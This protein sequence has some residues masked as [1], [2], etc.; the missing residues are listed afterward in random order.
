MPGNRAGRQ[1]RL[2]QVVEVSRRS[3]PNTQGRG[4]ENADTP[5]EV[6]IPGELCTVS[7]S[8]PESDSVAGRLGGQGLSRWESRLGGGGNY[9][10]QS[11]PKGNEMIHLLPW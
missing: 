2:R 9:V 10:N 4:A 3:N 6:D 11:G 8:V 1:G 5:G 7:T